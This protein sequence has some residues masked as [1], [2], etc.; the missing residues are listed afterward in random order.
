LRLGLITLLLPLI[1]LSS[2]DLDFC[3]LESTRYTSTPPPFHCPLSP[4]F[5]LPSLPSSVMLYDLFIGARDELQKLRGSIIFHACREPYTYWFVDAG[6]LLPALTKK[7]YAFNKVL[8]VTSGDF[9]NLAYEFL[10]KSGTCGPRSAP[11]EATN[12]CGCM[13]ET[14]I[15]IS[16]S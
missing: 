1:E 3:P 11:L 12:T 7:F 10:R 8:L 15:T 2:G 5:H 13:Q 4:H 6:L 16:T 9:Q 14:K